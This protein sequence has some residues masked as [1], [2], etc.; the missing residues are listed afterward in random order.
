M[1][2]ETSARP[3]RQSSNM[4]PFAP[5]YCVSRINVDKR[6]LDTKRSA[7]I[8][9]SSEVTM[10]VPLSLRCTQIFGAEPLPVY[11]IRAAARCDRGGGPSSDAPRK[12]SLA[13]RPIRLAFNCAIEAQSII[14]LQD[15]RPQPEGQI[16]RQSD[17]QSADGERSRCIS[18]RGESNEPHEAN[19]MD[20]F[21]QTGPS[22][23]LPER[24]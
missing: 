3:V 19:Q 4:F 24:N 18:L 22:L 5:S 7:A 15:H 11:R 21:I 23:V 6:A 17:D 16:Q 13:F 9:A 12:S 1:P 10:T 2:G 8:I 14:S 20:R